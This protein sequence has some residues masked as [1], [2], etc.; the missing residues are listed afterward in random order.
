VYTQT[1]LFRQNAETV[2]TGGDGAVYAYF[3]DKKTREIFKIDPE[4]LNFEYMFDID[5]NKSAWLYPGEGD[6]LF[7]GVGEYLYSIDEK[8]KTKTVFKWGTNGMYTVRS[9][10]DCPT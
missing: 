2:S 3:Y 7:Y 8:G 10:T 9:F 1:R 5:L 4:T 6:A